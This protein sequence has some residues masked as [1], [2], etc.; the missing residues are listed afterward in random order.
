MSNVTEKPIENLP[1]YKNELNIGEVDTTGKTNFNLYNLHILYE[2]TREEVLEHFGLNAGLDLTGVIP[3]LSEVAPKNEVLNPEGKYGFR[4]SYTVDENGNG[5][6]GELALHFDNQE[7]QFESADGMKYATIIFD[8]NTNRVDWLRSGLWGD[9][10]KQFYALT[11]STIAG[12]EA[13]IAKRSF[14]GNYGGYYAEF[15]TETLSVGLITHGL[16]ENETV[17]IFEYLTEFVGAVNGEADN[18]TSVGKANIPT[19]GINFN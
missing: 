18:D 2:M 16:S 17:A 11:A 14:D 8:H 10:A 15:H 1:K 5:S 6:W 4:R 12:V 19:K 7:F 3:Y 13:R 9:A